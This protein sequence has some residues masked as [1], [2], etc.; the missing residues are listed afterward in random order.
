MLGIASH[1]GN[2]DQT[3]VRYHFTP[4]RRALVR[5]TEGEL[6]RGGGIRVLTRC[7][8]GRKVNTAWHFLQMLNI[9]TVRNSNPRCVL[10][11][12]ENMS[13]QKLVRKCQST[14]HISQREEA[15]QMSFS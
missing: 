6:A 11:Q 1:Q 7:W 15:S 12:K 13:T 10:K 9:V 5:T 8:W 4:P 2:A 3:T 14:I